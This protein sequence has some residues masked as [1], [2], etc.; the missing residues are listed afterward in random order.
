MCCKPSEPGSPLSRRSTRAWRF[1]R[2]RSGVR[3]NRISPNHFDCFSFRQP[4]FRKLPPPP[5]RKHSLKCPS[6]LICFP[7]QIS[8]RRLGS[9]HCWMTTGRY[10]RVHRSSLDCLVHELLLL[11]IFFA[12]RNVSY[13]R[14]LGVTLQ[15][16][17]ARRRE[18]I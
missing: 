8:E 7:E 6:F 11:T 9:R 17:R 2:M 13:C 4:A 5:P 18:E 16:V 15:A 3:K 14:S 10:L 12:P 1:Y